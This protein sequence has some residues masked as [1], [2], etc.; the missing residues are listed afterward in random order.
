MNVLA[1][2]VV[3]AAHKG[4]IHGEVLM[5]ITNVRSTYWIAYLK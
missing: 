4:T 1:E 3:V 2:K 5:T